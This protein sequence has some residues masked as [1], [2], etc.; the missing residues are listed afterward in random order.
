MLRAPKTELKI[1]QPVWQLNTIC[2][3][4]PSLGLAPH[5]DT[6]GTRLI[7]TIQFSE[8]AKMRTVRD[9]KEGKGKATHLSKFIN[10]VGEDVEVDVHLQG[11]QRLIRHADKAVGN[12]HEQ[13]DQVK[14]LGRKTTISLF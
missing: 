8:G 5:Y 6:F 14:Y 11:I 12:K 2:L 9:V 4:H 1:G 3:T 10:G 7:S 13:K